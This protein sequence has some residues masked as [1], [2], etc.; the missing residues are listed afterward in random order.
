MPTAGIEL[1]GDL[2]APVV[3]SPWP[4]VIRIWSRPAI[5][6]PAARPGRR[7]CRSPRDR[8]AGGRRS[9]SGKAGMAQPD[10]LHGDLPSSAMDTPRRL[11]GGTVDG[12]DSRRQPLCERTDAGLLV[13]AGQRLSAFQWRRSAGGCSGI[14]AIPAHARPPAGG[15][16]VGSFLFTRWPRAQAGLADV[17]PIWSSC[18]SIWGSRPSG[19]SACPSGRGRGNPRSCRS[20]LWSR[21]AA[22]RLFGGLNGSEGYLPVTGRARA[23]CAALR[24]RAP[25]TA[26]RLAMGAGLFAISLGFRT[27]DADLCPVFPL[28]THFLWHLLNAVL[29]GWMIATLVRHEARSGARSEADSGP[30]LRGGGAR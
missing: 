18:C 25:A 12:L 9:R 5:A 8:R 6:S 30:G 3:W 22:T 11:D 29:L 23:L 19:S 7:G 24:R 4:W 28:G 1:L 14:G 20:P 16:G 26:G 13:G 27:L 10:N 21:V 15:I 2:G 17:L